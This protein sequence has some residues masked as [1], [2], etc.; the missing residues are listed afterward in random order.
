MGD[1][2]AP[3]KPEFWIFWVTW[4][5]L[6]VLIIVWWWTS[7]IVGRWGTKVKSSLVSLRTTHQE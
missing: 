2:F 7:R 1:D 3:G 6:S 5:S 4:I